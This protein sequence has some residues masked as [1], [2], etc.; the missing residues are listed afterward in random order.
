MPQHYDLSRLK[1]LLVDDCRFMRSVVSRVLQMLGVTQIEI[2]RDGLEAFEMVGTF[3][4]DI[5]ILDWEMV[6]MNG[7]DFVRYLRL[8]EDSPN[9]YMPVIMLTGYTERRKVEEARDAGITEFLAK[10]VS[11]QGLYSRL[12]SIVE[13]PRPFIRTLDFFGPDRRR[14]VSSKYDGPERRVGEEVVL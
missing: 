12:V 11:A 13:N 10:P 3:R 7:P 1:L 6:P 2:A 8:N 4:P 9:P 5:V 14:V